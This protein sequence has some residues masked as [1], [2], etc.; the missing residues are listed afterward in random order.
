MKRSVLVSMAFIFMAILLLALPPPGA[1]ANA[2]MDTLMIASLPPATMDSAGVIAMPGHASLDTIY[3][4]TAIHEN[5]QTGTKS[6]SSKETTIG[7]TER[8]QEPGIYAIWRSSPLIK[9]IYAEQNNSC[10]DWRSHPLIKP[11]VARS[12]VASTNIW[13]RCPLTRQTLT[14]GDCLFLP[15]LHPTTPITA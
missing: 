2:K 6:S 11:T 1:L 3:A 15:I 5:S 7:A 10:A 14:L 12:I 13:K 4:F 9:P 8:A